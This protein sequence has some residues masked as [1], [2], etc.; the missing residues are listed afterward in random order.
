MTKAV[1]LCPN[2]ENH[3]PCPEG[4]LQWHAWAREMLRTH[5]STKCGGCGLYK[6]WVPKRKKAPPLSDGAFRP[7]PFSSGCG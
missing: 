6:I 3:T 2:F 1:T 5:R 7:K 4:Y